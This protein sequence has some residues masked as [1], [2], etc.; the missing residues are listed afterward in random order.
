MRELPAQD[1]QQLAA[2]L[3]KLSEPLD[4]DAVLSFQS[5]LTLGR[6]SQNPESDP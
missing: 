1:E 4:L 2:V 3:A 5:S 6:V